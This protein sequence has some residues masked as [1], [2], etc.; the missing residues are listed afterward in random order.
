MSTASASTFEIPPS[1]ATA[2]DGSHF[3]ARIWADD[4]LMAVT[5]YF[6]KKGD[7][8]QLVGLERHWPGKVIATPEFEIDTGRS[9]YTDLQDRQ[10]ELF[11]VFTKNYNEETE[12]N[13]TG[14]E[15]FDSLPISYRTTYDA[16]TH[17]LMN[18]Q[19]TDEEG[20]SLD[21]A[22]DLVE[23]VDRIAGQYYGRSG[24]EQFRIYADLVPNARETLDESQEFFRD[25]EN[26]VYHVGYPTS[27]RQIGRVPNIQF[28]VSGDGTRADIDVDYRSSKMPQA[29]FNGH[30][31]SANSDVRAGDNSVRHAARWEGFVAWWRE[32]F[33]GLK[34][35][36]DSRGT[37]ILAQELP[38]PP[39]PLPADRPRDAEPAEIHEAAQEF[40]TDWL[41][42]R[43]PEEALK[44]LS[45]RALACLNTDDDVTLELLRENQARDVVRTLME[46]TNDELGDRDNLTE[47]IDIILPWDPTSLVVGQPYEEDFALVEMPDEKAVQYLCDRK[48]TRQE[49]ESTE[50]GN[51]TYGTYYA[52]VFRFKAEGGGVL[53]LLWEREGRG[54]R[55]VSYRSFQQ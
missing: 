1:T 55:I 10:T 9:R 24:D 2:V 38:E 8:L 53:G 11:D 42:R 40:L 30:L 50:A 7:G 48:P 22:I 15:H 16:V 6:R 18:S 23:R 28:S 37:D 35:R 54:W 13:L 20:N 39:T 47:A 12:K 49:A 34:K 44:F 52:V 32:V 21:T 33:G 51:L 36:K 45:D 19:L 17:A 31:T 26:T 29:M 14:Q 27:F 5:V 4:P 41:V 3:A 46:Y 25:K 43:K